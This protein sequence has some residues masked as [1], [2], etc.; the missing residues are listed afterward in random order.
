MSVTFD[1][2]AGHA[3]ALWTDTHQLVPIRRDGTLVTN[4]NL[5]LNAGD[6]GSY[7]GR[8]FP[9]TAQSQ[10][11]VVRK[12][13]DMALKAAEEMGI[14]LKTLADVTEIPQ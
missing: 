6:S 9:E 10:V 13:S 11:S 1:V 8:T 7:V 2:P 4:A 12:V 5:R 14:D 3:G